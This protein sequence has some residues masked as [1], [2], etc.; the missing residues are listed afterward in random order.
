MMLYDK[1]SNMQF[2]QN[3]GQFCFVFNLIL[4]GICYLNLDATRSQSLLSCIKGFFFFVTKWIDW[5]LQVPSC[6]PDLQL[7][8]KGHMWRHSSRL[9]W[10]GTDAAVTMNSA[11]QE[12]KWCLCVCEVQYDLLRTQAVWQTSRT[13]NSVSEPPKKKKFGQ[14][15][16][17]C[18][19]RTWC[20]TASRTL[21]HN[22]FFKSIVHAR[23]RR[24][25]TAAEE[26]IGG[27]ILNK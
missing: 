3:F 22:I 4:V 13:F 15:A 19:C 5:L 12:G 18:F 21:G 8:I 17:G 14:N 1:M 20:S 26:W 25:P 9:W 23:A 6:I 16:H 10:R 11:L 27:E 2:R 24:S 7:D